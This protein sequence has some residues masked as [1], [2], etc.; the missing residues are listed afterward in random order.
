VLRADVVVL[1][2]SRLVLREDDHLPCPFRESLEHG[3]LD[4]PFP[5]DPE[6]AGRRLRVKGTTDRT[7]RL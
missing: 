2:S 6:S 7:R 4:P 3:C 5:R 1:E